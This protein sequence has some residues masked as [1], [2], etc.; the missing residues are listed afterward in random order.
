MVQIAREPR[1]GMQKVVNTVT[2]IGP[3]FE[4]HILED[5]TEPDCARAQ[6]LDIRQLG[7]DSRKITALKPKEL[8][9]IERLVARRRRGIVEPVDHH[10]VNPGIA[11]VDGRRK[12]YGRAA[13]VLYLAEEGLKRR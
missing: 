7:L 13:R 3:V 10:E 2:V 12:G 8:G 6:P 11:P 5:G 4:R 9:V 1:I